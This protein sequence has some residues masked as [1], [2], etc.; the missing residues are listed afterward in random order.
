MN[1]RDDSLII[2]GGLAGLFAAL[3]LARE[4][5]RVRLLE[6]SRHFGGRAWTRFEAGL[7]FNLGPHALYRRGAAR[8]ELSAEGILIDGV[9]APVHGARAWYQQRGFALPAG[10]VSLL[11]TGLLSAR[12]KLELAKVLASLDRIEPS[13]WVGQPVQTWI[14]AS[15]Q[16][17][18]ARQLLQAFVRL[19]TYAHA[20]RALDAGS[21]LAQLKGA[22]G[23]VLYLHGGWGAL[24]TRLVEAA[25]EAGAQLDLG[26]AARSLRTQGAGFE[27]GSEA[28]TYEAS[29]VILA[30]SPRRAAELSPRPIDPKPGVIARAA[31]LDVGLKTLPHPR[32]TFAL[33]VDTPWYAS[34]HSSVARLGEGQV[35]HVARYL[36]PGESPPSRAVMEATLERLQP[37]FRDHLLRAAYH[38]RM[39]VSHGL[40]S[41]EQG[42]VRPSPEVPEIRGLFLAG[43]WVGQ[44][45][46]LA[47]AAIASASAASSSILARWGARGA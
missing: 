12:G 3:R 2:G 37:G 30:V 10:P 7:A 29:T 11:A 6:A 40:P 23:G 34:V 17:L 14:E 27:V 43:D 41:A 38:P 45:G 13:A 15:A 31:C 21:T 20:P 4:G 19:S 18:V 36:E 35:V 42:G 26:I 32:R 46:M 24:V 44:E 39:I 1:A 8:R 16:D 9:P 25:R 22:A 5:Q 47:D 33:G 28:G